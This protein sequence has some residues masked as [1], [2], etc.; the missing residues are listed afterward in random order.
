MVICCRGVTTDASWAS[1][2]VWEREP[3]RG[4]SALS[5]ARLLAESVMLISVAFSKLLA[6]GVLAAG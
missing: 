1:L 6:S 3:L 2:G 4:F 5:G